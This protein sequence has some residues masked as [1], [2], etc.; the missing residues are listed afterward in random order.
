MFL[1]KEARNISCFF[2][3]KE[4]RNI[5]CLF[6]TE[7]GTRGGGCG[8]S[9]HNQAVCLRRM[10]NEVPHEPLLAAPPLNMQVYC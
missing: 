6:F 8:S 7:R 3:Q 9:G 2:L 10:L 1:Q 5:S 4:A